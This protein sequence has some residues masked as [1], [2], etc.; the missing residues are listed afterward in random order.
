VA[1]ADKYS[2]EY[3]N[4]YQEQLLTAEWQSRRLEILRRDNYTCQKCGAKAADESLHVHHKGY[5]STLLPW[6]YPDD[7][8]ITLCESC[9]QEVH[10]G[11]I[12]S[13][14]SVYALVEYI[15][16]FDDKSDF[17]LEKMCDK[18]ED[19]KH[20]WCEYIWSYHPWVEMHHPFLCGTCLPAKEY[21]FYKK[22]KYNL[23]DIKAYSWSGKTAYDVMLDWRLKE[24]CDYNLEDNN[25][26][27]HRPIKQGYKYNYYAPGYYKI[28]YLY[29]DTIGA[30]YSAKDTNDFVAE[31]I[32]LPRHSLDNSKPDDIRL[33]DVILIKR[34]DLR[35]YNRYEV[36]WLNWSRRKEL[37]ELVVELS[38]L[39]VRYDSAIDSN[40][41]WSVEFHSGADRS[42]F[43][44]PF[45]DEALNW[46]SSEIRRLEREI[47][48]KTQ[49]L[50]R[51]Q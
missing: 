6:E 16:S 30:F 28:I 39:R 2:A 13:F 32:I 40:S 51:K 12:R 37:E 14:A 7:A 9:H 5:V 4:F 17:D 42:S 20:Q 10:E 1:S 11:R 38:R 44:P 3:S 34:C 23:D 22:N 29:E 15:H 19:Y 45:P 50:I 35:D 43:K 31:E 47:K 27:E 41:Q 8:L 21:E 36:D 24:N 26:W 25:S 49:E 18:W 46:M 33:G 48:Y